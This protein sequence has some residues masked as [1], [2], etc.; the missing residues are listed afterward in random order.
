MKKVSIYY[1]VYILG[2]FALV[3]YLLIYIFELV[4]YIQIR[5]GD[6]ISAEV[7]NISNN[8]HG[9]SGSVISIHTRSLKYGKLENG[10]LVQVPSNTIPRLPQHYISIPV[11]SI[12]AEGN[13]SM[14]YLDVILGKNG[15]IWITSK[16]TRIYIHT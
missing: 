12:S 3:R 11:L 5:I 16:Y 9:D 2:V 7:Q 10:V 15:F 14:N 8:T 6:C 4:Q 1:C 13:T